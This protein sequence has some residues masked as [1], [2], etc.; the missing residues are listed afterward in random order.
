MNLPITSKEQIISVCQR[1]AKEKGLS[2]I[3]MRAVAA[4]CNV[5]VGAIYNYFPSK[6]ELLCAAIESIW[7]DIFHMTQEPFEF[8]DF[9]ECL[10]WL[11]ESIQRGSRKYP[12]FLS[13]HAMA[14]AS[15]DKAIGQQMMANY[16]VHLK[17]NLEE[18]LKN[19]TKIRKDA[20]SQSLSPALFV[21]Y[22]FQLFLASI[23]GANQDYQGILELAGRYL[24]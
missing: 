17:T 13:S 12:Q 4:E 22:I 7:K 18:V 19:D 23:V 14:L 24:Y 1:L 16:F 6:S 20:F 8:T 21:D 15:E 5:S 9:I 10:S 3:S 2:S 11:F